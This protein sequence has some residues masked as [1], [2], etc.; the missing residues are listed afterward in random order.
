[1][2]L[3]E[4]TLRRIINE[5]MNED[6]APAPPVDPTNAEAP[7]AKRPGSARAPDLK[8]FKA[9]CNMMADAAGRV[10]QI[11]D[12]GRGETK[13]ALRWLDKVVQYAQTAQKILKH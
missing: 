10:K 7:Q 1:M 11:L 4:K 9:N 6:L 8:G 12:A 13:E 3:T 2:K 5:V